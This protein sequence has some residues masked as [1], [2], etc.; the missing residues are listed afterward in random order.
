MAM[1]LEE[2]EMETVEYVPA[3]EVMCTV[4][5]QPPSHCGCNQG[6]SGDYGDS[7][8]Q[9]GGG[10][11]SGHGCYQPQP[12]GDYRPTPVVDQNSQGTY[13]AEG[14]RGFSVLSGNNVLDGFNFNG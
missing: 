9:Q 7:G 11:H 10:D 8:W 13:V 4:W 3:R 12:G 5:Y 14:G 6:H 1:S 2:I